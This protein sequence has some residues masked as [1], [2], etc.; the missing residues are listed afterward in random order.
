MGS[1]SSKHNPSSCEPLSKETVKE[2]CEDTGFTEEEL[3]AWHT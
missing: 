1:K 3:L 2:L